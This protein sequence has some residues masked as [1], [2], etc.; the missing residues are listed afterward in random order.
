MC[1][2]GEGL[3]VRVACCGWR[4]LWRHGRRV[5]GL[6]GVVAERARVRVGGLWILEV[7]V[8]AAK[9]GGQGCMLACWGVA[10]LVM[11]AAGG[12]GKGRRRAEVQ[13]AARL[14]AAVRESAGGSSARRT[15]FPSC[16]VCSHVHRNLRSGEVGLGG[17]FIYN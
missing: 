9:G 15:C 17:T 7:G 12:V 8:A 6:F 10:V 2:L 13:V 4:G 16:S 11:R 14:A 1:V 5:C 3:G